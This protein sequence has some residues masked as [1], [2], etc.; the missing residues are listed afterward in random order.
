MN[1]FDTLQTFSEVSVTLVGLIAVVV[2][3]RGRTER[4]WSKHEIYGAIHV[5]LPGLIT[6]FSSLTA[7]SLF[8]AYGESELTWRIAHAVFAVFHSV[9]P[10]LFFFFQDPDSRGMFDGQMTKVFGLVSTLIICISLSIA[11][12]F[13]LQHAHIAFYLGLLWIFGA[14]AFAFGNMLVRSSTDDA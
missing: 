10:I 6:M 9:G 1:S 12:G 5:L 13:L 14:N 3:L 2:V 7:L 8:G 11:A 4:A